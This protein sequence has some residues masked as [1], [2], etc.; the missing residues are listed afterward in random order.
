M[1]PPS[2]SRPQDRDINDYLVA[3]SPATGPGIDEDDDDDIIDH[4]NHLSDDTSHDELDDDSQ[5]GDRY[6]F[7]KVGK[8]PQRSKF[9]D[10]L[11]V[12][13]GT[14]LSYLIFPS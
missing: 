2:R 11:E 12:S 10:D 6:V 8:K 4:G 14:Y 5:D 9:G 7:E 13:E 1:K 3:S